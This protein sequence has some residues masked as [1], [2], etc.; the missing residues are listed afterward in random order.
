VSVPYNRGPVTDAHIAVLRAEFGAT[1][2]Y[3]T[4]VPG[5]ATLPDPEATYS[6]VHQVDCVG[7]M[8]SEAQWLQEKAFHLLTDRTAGNFDTPIEIPAGRVV[9]DRLLDAG[10]LGGVTPQGTPAQYLY[11]T[12]DRYTSWITP[13]EL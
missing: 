6:I 3:D 8:R 2:V 10:A 4:V 13:S 5:T 7:R 9:A 1:K 12:Q 11:V